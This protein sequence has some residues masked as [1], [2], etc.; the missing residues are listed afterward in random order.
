MNGDA[1]KSDISAV[2]SVM[3]AIRTANSRCAE[4]GDDRIRSRSERE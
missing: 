4:A 2:A 3:V 1:S